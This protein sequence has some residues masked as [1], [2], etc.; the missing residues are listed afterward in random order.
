MD[1]GLTISNKKR[2]WYEFS[3]NKIEFFHISPPVSLPLVLKIR[4]D[5]FLV[6]SNQISN[7]VRFQPVAKSIIVQIPIIHM[8]LQHIRNATHW[9]LS[10]GSG[11]FLKYFAIESNSGGKDSFNEWR[12]FSQRKRIIFFFYFF[13]VFFSLTGFEWHIKF[14]ILLH[15]QQQRHENDIKI[16]TSQ[17]ALHK[18]PIV[19]FRPKSEWSDTAWN[20]I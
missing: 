16:S 5:C 15:R 1:I 9:M 2:N 8:R 14:T 13:L 20:S 12:I 10:Y 4:H 17:M 6:F 19:I 3:S 18:T 11:I 7:F